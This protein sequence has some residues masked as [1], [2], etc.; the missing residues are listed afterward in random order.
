MLKALEDVAAFQ[1]T[2]REQMLSRAHNSLL[3]ISVGKRETKSTNWNEVENPH[4]HVEG[5]GEMRGE[6]RKHILY[7][8]LQVVVDIFIFNTLLRWKWP[9]R[10]KQKASVLGLKSYIYINIQ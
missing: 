3:F 8:V 5:K 4:K 1:S 9:L 10:G 2:P 7:K 6:E